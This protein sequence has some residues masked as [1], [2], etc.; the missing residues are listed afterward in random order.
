MMMAR[1]SDE[2]EKKV[3]SFARASE[4]QRRKTPLNDDFCANFLNVAH[5]F[6]CLICSNFLTRKKGSQNERFVRFRMK[7]GFLSS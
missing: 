1:S 3:L 6:S 4:R 2:C 7:M 5:L